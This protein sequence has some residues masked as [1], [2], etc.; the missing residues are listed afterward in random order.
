MLTAPRK[1][2]HDETA[3][4]IYTNDGI[5]YKINKTQARDLAARHGW[6]YKTFKAD[7]DGTSNPHGAHDTGVVIASPQMI[8]YAKTLENRAA[9]ARRRR[10]RDQRAR[11][12]LADLL[13]EKITR[14][15]DAPAAAP[16]NPAANQSPAT[17]PAPRVANTRPAPHTPPPSRAYRAPLTA[18]A[19]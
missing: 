9:A 13:I 1:P 19:I 16:Q 8:D 10:E 2:R 15:L 3:V 6:S 5:S 18:L 4:T 14:R 11:A 17:R 12:F 7:A